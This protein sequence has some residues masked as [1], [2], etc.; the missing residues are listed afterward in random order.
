MEEV[1]FSHMD[2]SKVITMAGLF[3]G[4]YKLTKIIYGDKFNTSIVT[5]LNELFA[6]CHGLTEVDLSKLDTKKVNTMDQMFEY[7]GNLK[8]ITFGQ[9]FNT[10]EV[11]RMRRMFANC[12]SLKS[13]DLSK[14]NTSQVTMFESMFEG[15]ISLESIDTKKLTH[16]RH[17]ISQECLMVVLI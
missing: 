2:T 4:C 15:C 3:K 11:K 7:S 17:T 8:K 16:V 1:D 14:F 13:V 5:A 12:E 6:S 10:A 9:N